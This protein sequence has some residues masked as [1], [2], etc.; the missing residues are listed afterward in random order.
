MRIK[1]FSKVKAIIYFLIFILLIINSFSFYFTGRMV[2]RTYLYSNSKNLESI[3][4][5]LLENFNDLL[6]DS[7]ILN[8]KVKEKSQETGLRITLVD[9]TGKVIADSHQDYRLMENHKGRNDIDEA[10]EGKS[11]TVERYSKTLHDKMIYFSMPIYQNDEI[12]GV[13][14]LSSFSKDID[15]ILFNIF[16]DY[17]FV[18]VFNLLFI[19]QFFTF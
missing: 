10:L 8:Q 4:K 11:I 14:R 3:S 13:I 16:R 15:R 1:E 6:N 12:I 2:K 7:E 18:F 9:K 5:L 19:F 17:I